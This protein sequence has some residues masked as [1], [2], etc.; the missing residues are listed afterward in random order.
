MA[1]KR[2]HKLEI[3]TPALLLDLDMLERNIR[4]M[5]EFARQAGVNL[6]PHIKTHK[7]PA[8]A[9]RQVA[10]GAIGVTCATL[11]EAEVMVAAGIPD[12]LISRA[13]VGRG[14]IA[15]LAGLAR[16]ADVKV[17][18][19]N[20][21]NV[22]DLSEA[23]VAFGSR[24]GVLIEVDVG[25]SRC[26]VAPGT[27]ECLALA[28]QIT[29]SEGLQ[30]KG[31]Q[32]YEGHVVLLKEH[33][34]REE[35]AARANEAVVNTREKLEQQ[36]IEVPI[37]TGG[38]TGTFDLTGKRKG[39]TEIQPGSYATMDASYSDLVGD[40]FEPALTLLTTVISRPSADRAV[41]D[42]G[43]KA[44]STDYGPARP[45]GLPGVEYRGGGDEHGILKL[46]AESLDL[47]VGDLVELY[48]SHG[49]TTV[50]LH[51][52]FYGIRNDHL[53]VVLEIVA[54]GRFD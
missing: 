22:R 34:Q 39:I 45:K 29:T 51:E 33:R 17:V 43:S 2:V 12:V 36:G 9:H 20:P 14:K 11:G 18:A 27:P 26:G 3:Q 46:G 50:N 8:I 41:V 52:R 53:E 42:A 13:V 6:R 5:A 21:V 16:H 10:A 1:L 37:V 44:L 35:G 54:R 7:C 32:G 15:R 24:I 19:D 30:F 4:R 49:C 23:A 40:L 38:G 25:Q 48:P 47:Q 28:R 31:L